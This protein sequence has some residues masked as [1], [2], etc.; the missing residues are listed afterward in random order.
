MANCIEQGLLK[1]GDVLIM[2]NVAT[3]H[4]YEDVLEDLLFSC[5]IG[6]LFLPPY[7]PELNPI[8]LAFNKFK[9]LIRNQGDKST[10]E[11]ALASCAWALDAITCQDMDR[12]YKHAGY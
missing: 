6:L 1:E 5:G 7:S 10:R 3:H 2:D 12:F 9:Y 11:G 8:E 4:Q